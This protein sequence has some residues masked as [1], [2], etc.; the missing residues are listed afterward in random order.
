MGVRK[1][2][3]HEQ[4][5]LKKVDFVEWKSDDTLKVNRILRKYHIQKRE[6]YT[7]YNKLCGA[8]HQLANKVKELNAKD[9]F[10]VATTAK[11]LTKLHHLGLI[12]LSS[13]TP[14]DNG[15]NKDG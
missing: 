5:L 11:L 3:F 8:V 6:D 7:K 10:R 4:K 1:L 14:S 12:V 9:P 13:T 15:Q 2:K